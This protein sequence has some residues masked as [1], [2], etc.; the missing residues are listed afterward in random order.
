MALFH[1]VRVPIPPGRHQL[2]RVQSSSIYIM[3]G[4][5]V[6]VDGAGRS[7]VP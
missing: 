7:G 5:A 6:I 1:S 3:L 2:R 4:V